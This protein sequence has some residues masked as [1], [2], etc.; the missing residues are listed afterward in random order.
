MSWFVSKFNID[1]LIIEWKLLFFPLSLFIIFYRTKNISSKTMQIFSIQ[2]PIQYW[3]NITS[4][5]LSEKKTCL[6]MPLWFTHYTL[7]AYYLPWKTP[8]GHYYFNIITFHFNIIIT[9]VSI[10]LVYILH[11]SHFIRY[12]HQHFSNKFFFLSTFFFCN[13]CLLFSVLYLQSNGM[14]QVTQRDGFVF[15]FFFFCCSM[16]EFFFLSMPFRELINEKLLKYSSD[17]NEYE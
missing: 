9:T 16:D 4:F 6:L 13:I 5:Y 15:E 2:Y 14:S 12:L 1:E 7:H 3:N 17:R 11:S 8:R 10:L